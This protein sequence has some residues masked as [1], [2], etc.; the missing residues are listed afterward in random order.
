MQEGQPFYWD[1]TAGQWLPMANVGG[2][3]G[4]VPISQL[5]AE[6]RGM[7][8]GS[9]PYSIDPVLR[10]AEDRAT[11]KTKQ[12]QD[13]Q[14]LLAGTTHDPTA[15]TLPAGYNAEEYIQSQYPS[16]SKKYSYDEIVTMSDVD[17]AYYEHIAFNAELAESDWGFRISSMYLRAQA[18][19]LRP[20]LK[21]IPGARGLLRG[22]EGVGLFGETSD[23]THDAFARLNE[24]INRQV[25]DAEKDPRM[26]PIAR[27]SIRQAMNEIYTLRDISKGAS[28]TNVDYWEDNGLTI[29][30]TCATY[31][32]ILNGYIIKLN[33]LEGI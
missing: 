29:H 12:E 16:L 31:D 27:D 19:F 14:N 6:Q 8:E 4:H 1:K 3:F 32:E 28:G 26:I 24:T 30:Q 23:D 7:G 21:S 10:A 2:A 15:E 22:A 18:K 5:E 25:S 17:R 13:A 33:A 11:A 20:I 9:L